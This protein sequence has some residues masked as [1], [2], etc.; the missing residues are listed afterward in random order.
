MAQ[1]MSFSAA[2]NLKTNHS[3]RAFAVSALTKKGSQS[4]KPYL[5]LDSDY[6]QKLIYLDI[7][8]FYLK[9]YIDK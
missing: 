2:I 8:K 9:K 1:T 6:Q 3:D 4:I 5:E 7:F